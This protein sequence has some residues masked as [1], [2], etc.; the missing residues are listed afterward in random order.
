MDARRIILTCEKLLLTLILL[1]E[2]KV[3]YLTLHV[4][5]SKGIF[6]INISIR[7]VGNIIIYENK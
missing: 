7:P 5:M 1:S 2:I 3:H 6:K 4:Q